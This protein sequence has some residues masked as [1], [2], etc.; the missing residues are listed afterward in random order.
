MGSSGGE[1][2]WVVGCQRRDDCVAIKRQL[3]GDLTSGPMLGLSIVV[4]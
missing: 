3:G 2:A 4:G 1:T